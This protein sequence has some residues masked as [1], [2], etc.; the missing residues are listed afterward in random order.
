MTPAARIAAAIEVLDEGLAGTAIEVILQK[1]AR[2]HRFAGSK[3]R[4]AIRDLVFE[5]LRAK[6]SLGVIGGGTDGR[7]L[8]LGL[9]KRDGLDFATLFS[10]D[11]YGPAP[12]TAVEQAVLDADPDLTLAEQ[13]DLSDWLWP[14]WQDNLGA[15]AMSVAQTMRHRAP[16]TLRVNH[17]RADVDD[18]MQKLLVDGIVTRKID[19][20]F[21]LQVIENER[22]IKNSPAYLD[23]LVELQDLASQ[24]ALEGFD[25]AETA[26]VLDYCAGGGG[27]ALGLADYYGVAVVA[28]DIAPQRMID[29]PERAH[30]ANARVTP[31]NPEDIS[32]LQCDLVFCDAPCSGSGTWRR[33]PEAKWALTVEKLQN[34]NAM[35][36][37][38]L[39]KSAGYVGKDGLLAYATCSILHAENQDRITAF[40]RDHPDWKLETQ[41]QL[42]PDAQK[43]GFFRATLR[44]GS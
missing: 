7:A 8:L 21:A 1:W 24:R 39:A 20:S 12:L 41:W 3:D 13:A 40:L 43:D 15:D 32:G 25:L 38:V 10:G 36:D 6:R 29:I 17:R 4:A 26:K 11:G 5:V 44:R 22:R 37:D 18:V 42:L 28:H 14:M 16:V 23:G 33:A 9:A 35:Q 2:S 31:V 27:K 34:L 30:R 19:N